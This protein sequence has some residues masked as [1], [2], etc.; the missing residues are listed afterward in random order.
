VSLPTFVVLKN[1]IILTHS[2]NSNVLLPNSTKVKVEEIG[3]IKITDDIFLH[4]VFYIPIFYFNILSLL[5]LIN[6]NMFWFITQHDSFLAGHKNLED[7]W[8]C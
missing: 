2:Q 8:H 1:Y 4:N 6:D 5:T 3:S 7:D